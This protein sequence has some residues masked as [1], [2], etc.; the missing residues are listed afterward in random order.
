MIKVPYSVLRELEIFLVD[1]PIKG[2]GKSNLA[3]GILVLGTDFW[4]HPNDELD[5]RETLF[6]AECS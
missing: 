1:V 4:R 5:G 3:F 6:G 2:P